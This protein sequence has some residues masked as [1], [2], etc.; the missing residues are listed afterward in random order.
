MDYQKEPCTGEDDK[1]PKCKEKY[2]SDFNPI[3]IGAKR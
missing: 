1:D 2:G 3:G